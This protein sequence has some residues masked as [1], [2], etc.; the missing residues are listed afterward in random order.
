MKLTGKNVLITGASSGI[1]EECAKTFAEDGA[2]LILVARR[3]S[4]LLEISNEIA[5]KHNV[6][7]H[8][9]ELDVRNYNDIETKINSIPKEFLPIDILINNAGKALGVEKIQDGLLENWEE[10]IDTNIKGLL[11]VSRVVL[12]MMIKRQEGMVINIGSIAGHEVYVGGNVYCA[13]KYAVKALSKG[14]ML[15]VNGNNIRIASIDPGMVNTEFSLVRFKGDKD[16]ADNVYN[17]ITPLIGRDIAEIAL[18][19]ATRPPHVDIQ[20]VIVTPT[21]QASA[22]VVFRTSK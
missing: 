13:T 14:M 22:T 8:N 12:P 15:D 7:I 6:E 5:S 18:F 2:N 17:N 20:D 10:M 19:I 11:Y 16:K 1:G 9:I 3:N 4:R 21:A